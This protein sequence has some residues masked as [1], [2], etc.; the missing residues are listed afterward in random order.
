MSK[1]KSREQLRSDNF[2]KEDLNP[3]NDVFF[4][5]IF[6][7]PER[8]QITI[9]FLNDLLEEEL[10]HEIKDLTFTNSEYVPDKESDKLACLDIVCALDSGE[11]V[12]VEMQVARAQYSKTQLVLLVTDV[13]KLIFQG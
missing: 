8:K 7:R 10:G 2:T 1:I 6:G 11:M 3:T 4:K 12:D 5:F 13:F 9:A